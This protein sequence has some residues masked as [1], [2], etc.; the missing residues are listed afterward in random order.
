[1]ALEE[2]CNTNM[3]LAVLLRLINPGQLSESAKTSSSD[4]G[5]DKKQA[6]RSFLDEFAWLG[7][8]RTGGE[9]VTATAGV[10]MS[11]GP[12][13]LVASNNGVRQD[14]QD[15]LE[16]VL[17]SLQKLATSRADVRREV[18]TRLVNQSIA[19]SGAK[20]RNY[21]TQLTKLV[22]RMHKYESEPNSKT[23]KEQLL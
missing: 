10:T 20:V 12:V 11:K 15:H 21:N 23:G 1:M 18:E 2:V 8:C 13:L 16:L 7:D 4:H 14:V 22:M 6:W 17:G 9:T 5:N 3:E 19:L